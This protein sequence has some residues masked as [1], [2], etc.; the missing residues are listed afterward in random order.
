M[1][2]NHGGIRDPVARGCGQRSKPS[3]QGVLKINSRPKPLRI[4]NENRVNLV[5]WF[6]PHAPFFVTPEAKGVCVGGKVSPGK[7]SFRLCEGRVL[8]IAISKL[9]MKSPQILYRLVPQSS[10]DN[11]GRRQG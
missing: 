5:P 6:Y 2:A 8:V 9:C 3:R 4:A 10:K 11:L 1:L 7:E